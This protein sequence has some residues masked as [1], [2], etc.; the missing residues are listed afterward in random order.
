[1]K[2]NIT[3]YY[4]CYNYLLN[5][6]FR[7]KILKL[8]NHSCCLEGKYEIAS[9]M[10][11]YC[12]L[13]KKIAAYFVHFVRFKLR[14]NILPMSYI[15]MTKCDHVL[16]CIIL[17]VLIFI[18]VHVLKYINEICVYFMYNCK[19]LVYF[20]RVCC[21]HLGRGLL[22]TVLYYEKLFVT[23]KFDVTKFPCQT[24][25]YLMKFKETFIYFVY[26]L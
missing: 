23:W 3:A 16:L 20:T 2:C 26:V 25:P 4:V 9:A 13:M 14:I 10:L 24:G 1:M 18:Y 15:Q 12:I 11:K 8:T 22:N 17:Y 21:I 7:S 19:I 6:Q 5:S